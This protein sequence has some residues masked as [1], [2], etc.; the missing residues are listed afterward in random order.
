MAHP[1]FVVIVADGRSERLNLVLDSSAKPCAARRACWSIQLLIQ[2]REGPFPSADD[3]V[4]TSEMRRKAG[5]QIRGPQSERQL[6]DNRVDKPPFSLST[7]RRPI[8]ILNSR[9]NNEHRHE[10]STC[11]IGT[12]DIAA[13]GVVSQHCAQSLLVP[14]RLTFDLP[15]RGFDAVQSRQRNDQITV[16]HAPFEQH[17]PGRQAGMLAGQIGIQVSRRQSHNV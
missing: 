6:R 9:H 12:I 7:Q 4:S 10:K 11:G 13:V 5:R 1:Y 8:L 14:G 15:L 2:D 17:G 16:A 3:V